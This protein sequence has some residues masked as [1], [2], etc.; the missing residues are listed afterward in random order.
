M[1]TLDTH[2]SGDRSSSIVPHTLVPW[3][4][5]PRPRAGNDG[6]ENG[7]LAGVSPSVR[8][9]GASRRRRGQRAACVPTCV[10]R[11]TAKISKARAWPWLRRRPAACGA[12]VGILVGGLAIG[13]AYRRRRRRGRPRA[14]NGYKSVR[15][16][17][18]RAQ[19]P[20][21][22][23]SIMAITA[24]HFPFAEEAKGPVAE[25]KQ[26]M[27]RMNA[28][29][30]KKFSAPPSLIEEQTR[31][32]REERAK[33][34]I[35]AIAEETDEETSERSVTPSEPPTPE[36]D[37]QQQLKVGEG[38]NKLPW[39][40]VAD[41]PETNKPELYPVEGS[42]SLTSNE[43]SGRQILGIERKKHAFSELR[44]VP[45]RHRRDATNGSDGFALRFLD[46]DLR[47]HRQVLEDLN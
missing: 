41:P 31:A 14:P 19:T 5:E 10:L 3:D 17:L 43:V 20:S 30:R 23:R 28:A 7:I 9:A 26:R 36:V 34:K 44:P 37:G 16:G 42:W 45:R 25:A 33:L 38:A 27:A 18:G 2:P 22:D 4:V 11:A 29:R 12:R 35:G 47:G 8:P 46:H 21:Q 6:V 40:I 24:M 39:N 32:A 15:A 1:A 13:I